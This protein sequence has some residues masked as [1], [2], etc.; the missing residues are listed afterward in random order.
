MDPGKL[1]W[2][3]LALSFVSGLGLTTLVMQL[4][5]MVTDTIDQLRKTF[6]RLTSDAPKKRAKPQ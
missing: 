4:W 6:E 2:I 1:M 3:F 5:A